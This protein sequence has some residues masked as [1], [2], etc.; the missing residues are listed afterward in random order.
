ML[1]RIE[2][3]RTGLRV[4]R[5]CLGTGCWN[6]QRFALT[7]EQ[8]A[9]LV[10]Q[11]YDLGV[12][13]IDTA[14][15]YRTHAHV[16][17]GVKG[18]DR[19]DL[20]INTK[21]G[22][23]VADARAALEQSLR[24]LGVDYV[25]SVMLHGVRSAEDLQRREG[26]LEALCKAKDQGLIRMVGASTHVFTGSAMRACIDDPRIEA[27]LTLANKTGVGLKGGSYEEHVALIREAHQAGK[28]VIAMKVL[29]EGYLADEAEEHVRW[30]FAQPDLDAV[31]LGMMSRPQIEMAARIAA[32]E[33][34]SPELRA[35]AR[36]GAKREWGENFPNLYG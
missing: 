28:F 6:P 10:K 9:D 21:V 8:G 26:T 1:P 33:P 15:G 34:V 13:F 23:S 29:G 12:N 18:L 36:V 22:A 19:A 7:P 14:I 31:N 35:A 27:I 24:E 32:G 3:G 16:A 4:S 30:A 17:L 25:D 2:Y 11:A 20:V 5:L